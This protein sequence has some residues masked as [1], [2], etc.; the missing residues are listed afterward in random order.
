VSLHQ[1]G[2]EPS[3]LFFYSQVAWVK[4]QGRWEKKMI[5]NKIP[6]KHF[7]RRVGYYLSYPY[8]IWNSGED[9]N[10]RYIDS[11]NEFTINTA[12][13]LAKFAELVNSGYDFKGKKIKLV[14]DIV[15]NDIA[16]MEN[17]FEAPPKKNVWTPIGT[18]K[19]PFRGIF[20]GGGYVISGV[21]TGNRNDN[22]GLFGCIEMD[23]PNWQ[24]RN[25]WVIAFIKGRVSIGGLVGLKRQNFGYIRNNCSTIILDGTADIGGLVGTNQGKSKIFG[26]SSAGVAKAPSTTKRCEL[27]GNPSTSEEP[28]CLYGCSNGIVVYQPDTAIGIE[29]S[30]MEKNLF[31]QLRNRINKLPYRPSKTWSRYWGTIEVQKKDNCIVIDN[32]LRNADVKIYDKHSQAIIYSGNSGSSCILKIPVPIGIYIVEVNKENYPYPVDVR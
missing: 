26:S 28:L 30:N 27:I 1:G 7:L 12:E 6:F 25:L 16:N 5:E 13:Q 11:Q 29:I 8:P 14:R 18:D 4:Q 15:L 24:I 20:D 31:R 3:G 32:L 23:I 21:Y 9:P 17:W 2:A 10:W 19:N 22:Q